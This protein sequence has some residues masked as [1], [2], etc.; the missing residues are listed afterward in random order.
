MTR[1]EKCVLAI[2]A[3]AGLSLAWLIA[4]GV[5]APA[6]LAYFGWVV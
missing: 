1:Y 2:L 4:A 5:K 3:L 6:L